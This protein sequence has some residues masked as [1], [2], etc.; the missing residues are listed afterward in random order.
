MPNKFLLLTVG[1][2]LAALRFVYTFLPYFIV[3]DVIVFVT[4]AYLVLRRH[5]HAPWTA[6]LLLA[7]PAM[8]MLA[9]FTAVLGTRL[10]DGVG[11]GN[12]AALL[13]IPA[14][15]TIGWLLATRRS[16][17]TAQ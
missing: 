1:M 14:A 7:L 13:L 10:L 3:A 15:T 8:A 4:A 9:F 17:T 6:A 2:L 12:A 11:V 5:S 16:P